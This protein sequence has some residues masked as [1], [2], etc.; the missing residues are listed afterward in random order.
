ML[1]HPAPLACLEPMELIRGRAPASPIL[2]SPRRV[3]RH[4]GSSAQEAPCGARGPFPFL[5]PAPGAKGGGGQR[6]LAGRPKLGQCSWNPQ[7]VH[8][9]GGRRASCSQRGMSGWREGDEWMA[10]AGEGLSAKL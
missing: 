9:D 5:S 10:G 7:L 3:R 2:V 4:D 6:C 8:C 1:A